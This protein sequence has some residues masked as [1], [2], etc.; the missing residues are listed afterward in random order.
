MSFSSVTKRRKLRHAD[1]V[2]GLRA[3]RDRQGA[4]GYI[5][6]LGREQQLLA[7]LCQCAHQ[8]AHAYA[9]LGAH[10]GLAEFQNLIEL[11]GVH[12][13]AAIA[14]D[15]SRLRIVGTHHTHRRGIGFDVGE[16]R[17]NFLESLGAQHQPRP[18]MQTR[19]VRPG[20]TIHF[21]YHVL[22]PGRYGNTNSNLLCGGCK[23]ARFNNTSLGDD[24]GD[25]AIVW[26]R[27]PLDRWFCVPTFR[28][29]CP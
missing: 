12:R 18:A 1:V 13:G 2:R 17:R 25:P 27:S 6:H 28:W 9:G 22:P 19:C 5:A 16:D 23:T 26:L 3:R 15:A 4:H 8:S 21:G 14:A 20:R 7:A 10:R 11:T 29:V 24:T